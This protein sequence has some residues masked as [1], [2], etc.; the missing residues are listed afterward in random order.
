MATT[1]TARMGGLNCSRRNIRIKE[2]AIMCIRLRKDRHQERRREMVLFDEGI[3]GMRDWILCE[4]AM[5]IPIRLSVL[6]FYFLVIRLGV[7]T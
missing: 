2:L 3:E 4:N 7:L 5:M 6:R 1:I